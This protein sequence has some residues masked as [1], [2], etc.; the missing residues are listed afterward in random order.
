[1]E[2]NH[3]LYLIP[4]YSGDNA[5]LSIR[6]HIINIEAHA[7]LGNWDEP[8]MIKVAKARTTGKASRIVNSDTDFEGINN[9]KDFKEKLIKRFQ[10]HETAPQKTSA[11]AQCKQMP[12]ES[13]F[14]YINR[15]SYKADRAYPISK[16]LK[17]N[18]AI[19]KFIDQQKLEFFYNGLRPEFKSF[20]IG[21]EVTTLKE[22]IDKA[23]LYEEKIGTG[24]E[25]QPD[26][27]AIIPP[28]IQE[29][30]QQVATT[31]Q[32][33]ET[34]LLSQK[35]QALI[36]RLTAL[37]INKTDNEYEE[38]I[39]SLEKT[40]NQLTT[41]IDTHT[42]W[43]NATDVLV[44][45]KNN[46]RDKSPN[47]SFPP[48][49]FR[50]SENFKGTFSNQNFNND[51]RALVRFNNSR[52]QGNFRGNNNTGRGTFGR[53]PFRNFDRN[54]GLSRNGQSYGRAISPSRFRDRNNN[55]SYFNTRDN[56]FRNGP[57]SFD[58]PSRRYFNSPDRYVSNR[59]EFDRRFYRYDRSNITN[60]IV[61]QVVQLLGRNNQRV[62][63]GVKCHICGEMGHY[64]RE[65]KFG[66][67]R[68]VQGSS[69]PNS[70]LLALPWPEKKDQEKEE[71][72]LNRRAPLKVRFAREES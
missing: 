52:G 37:T 40:I 44:H 39:K 17:N 34:A 42:Q 69:S 50:S 38:R 1:M 31:T 35:T 58:G 3:L 68:P 65:H 70:A 21:K 55:D 26:A 51:N 6:Q 59:N 63:S 19:N 4:A 25:P 41:D 66:S 32:M 53:E 5:L 54:N 27:L 46:E 11:L 10:P 18:E 61:R 60:D 62:V 2:Q 72:S 12:G 8:F 48:R 7:P 29:Y 20:V 49:P 33:S 22:A 30:E 28:H 43:A 64:A 56:N 16:D 14:D 36:D 67:P 47:A 24:G 9:W 57:R 15:F 23:R 45:P 13:V 71:P